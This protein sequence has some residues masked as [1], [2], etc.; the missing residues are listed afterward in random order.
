MTS[1]PFA[2]RRD[3]DA[4]ETGTAFAPK[5]DSDGLIVAIAT[6]A[7][8]GDV[9]MV[10]WMNAEAVARTI[11]TRQAWFWSRSRKRLW[12]KGEESGNT[13]AVVDMRVDCDQDTLL[14]KVTMDGD[15]LACHRG[16][17]SCFYRA[18]P[19]GSTPTPDMKLSFD[20]A[21]PHKPA[22]KSPGLAD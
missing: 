19:L 15:G 6:E 9:L 16:Y 7:K 4:V 14:L 5:F 10:A 21:M 18:V 11:E 13:L 17:R 3:H 1:A 2:P 12:R 20:A 22:T 8:T